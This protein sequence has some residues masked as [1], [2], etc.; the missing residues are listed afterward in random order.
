MEEEVSTAPVS[1][2][3]ELTLKLLIITQAVAIVVEALEAFV[4]SM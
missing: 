2:R 3:F 4:L 1:S